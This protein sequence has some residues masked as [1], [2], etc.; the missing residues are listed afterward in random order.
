ME[1][2]WLQTLIEFGKPSAKAK[3]DP[4]GFAKAESAWSAQIAAVLQDGSLMDGELELLQAATDRFYRD[5]G[6]QFE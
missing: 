6:I 2:A 4:A 5:F 1:L 3:I